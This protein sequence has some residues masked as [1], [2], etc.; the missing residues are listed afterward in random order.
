MGTDPGH[1]WA[2]LNAKCERT[3]DAQCNGFR[4]AY[5]DAALSVS[6]APKRS[7]QA[8]KIYNQR[9]DRTGLAES[10]QPPFVGMGDSAAG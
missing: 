7:A 10:P 5:F 2:D 4:Q 3:V 6:Q 9:Q 8:V 1:G